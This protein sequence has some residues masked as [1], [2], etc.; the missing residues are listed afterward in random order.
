MSASENEQ[1]QC[2]THL[3]GIISSNAMVSQRQAPVAVV[4][5]MATNLCAGDGPSPEHWALERLALSRVVAPTATKLRWGS[6]L[7][8]RVGPWGGGR[9][10]SAVSENEARANYRKW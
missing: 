2:A 3:L 6:S 4:S 10:P 7:P 1:W 9:A 5:L 8:T